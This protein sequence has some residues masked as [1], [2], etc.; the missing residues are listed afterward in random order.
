M[1]ETGRGLP[2]SGFLNIDGRRLEFASHGPQPGESPV[3]VMLH[4]GL[5]SVSHWKDFPSKLASHCEC[6]VFAFSRAGYGRSSAARLPRPLN[7]MTLEA[8]DVLPKVLDAAGLR[9]AIVLGHSDGATIAAVHAGLAADPRVA[10]VIL[11]A[12]HFFAEKVGLESISKTK[13]DYIYGNLR[14]KL[15][16]YHDDVDNAFYGWCDAWLDRRFEN[17]SVSDAIDTIAV[18]VLAIQGERDPYGT[19][20]QIDELRARLRVPPQV[21]LMDDCGH[22]PQREQPHR[23]LDAIGRF[24]ERLEF[25]TAAP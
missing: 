13:N 3:I 25:C 10:G 21:V 19:I 14:E 2:D 16:P 20:A 6:R 24:V 8:I 9:S 5:G 7:Y 22:A 1:T 4:E 18:P 17:W 23:L 12:P 11:I 15:K